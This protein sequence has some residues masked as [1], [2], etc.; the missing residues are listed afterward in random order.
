MRSADEGSTIFYTVKDFVF[1]DPYRFVNRSDSVS[2]ARTVG[3]SIIK[4]LHT[5]TPKVQKRHTTPKPPTTLVIRATI[6]SRMGRLFLGSLF[7]LRERE[8]NWAG[9][10]CL[11]CKVE[12]QHKGGG[13]QDE[14]EVREKCRWNVRLERGKRLVEVLLR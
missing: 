4:G 8:K 10:H 3:A 6:N 11:R 13:Q 1:S 2:R 9:R 5:Y 14:G 7:T 12:C